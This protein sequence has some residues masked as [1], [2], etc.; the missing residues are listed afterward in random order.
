[1]LYLTHYVGHLEQLE[2]MRNIGDLQEISMLEMLNLMPGIE[3]MQ[4][5]E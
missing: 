3:S 5:A 4:A 1:M 2:T